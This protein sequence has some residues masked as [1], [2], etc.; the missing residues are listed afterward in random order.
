M[1]W[2]VEV[3]RSKWRIIDPTIW[4][5]YI[6]WFIIFISFAFLIKTLFSEKFHFSV[7]A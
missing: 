2:R 6:F 5:I 7:K 1:D 3:G 4:G